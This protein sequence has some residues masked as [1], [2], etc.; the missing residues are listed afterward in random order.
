MKKMIDTLDF[1]K[2]KN[3][4]LCPFLGGLTL[5]FHL[6]PWLLVVPH[7]PAR[8]LVLWEAVL[9]PGEGC[10]AL[11]L[12]AASHPPH[13]WPTAASGDSTA[14]CPVISHTDLQLNIRT[15]CWSPAF[16]YGWLSPDWQCPTAGQ[17][18]L[19]PRRELTHV[20][21][22]FLRLFQAGEWALPP[23]CLPSLLP[24][25]L[26]HTMPSFP[27]PAPPCLPLLWVAAA[28]RPVHLPLQVQ[29]LQAQQSALSLETKLTDECTSST[30]QAL[31]LWPA[32]TIVPAT[33]DPRSQRAPWCSVLRLPR[34]CACPAWLSS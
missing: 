29:G 16:P 15:S 28:E 20:P 32:D 30:P 12:A 34:G 26:A 33:S 13:P 19:G 25:C 10:T 17:E 4:A 31:S 9:C 22:G 27:A 24:P 3:S 2:I 18:V 21:F 11:W 5:S 1:I 14:A 8:V 6:S 7:S 23:P